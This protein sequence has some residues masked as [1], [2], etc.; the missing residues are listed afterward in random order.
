[1]PVLLLCRWLLLALLVLLLPRAW[2]LL[3]P[4]YSSLLRVYAKSYAERFMGSDSTLLAAVISTKTDSAAAF[5][6]GLLAL[7]GWCLKAS[8]LQ[9]EHTN[10]HHTDLT[11]TTHN[12][13]HVTHGGTMCRLAQ[14]CRQLPKDAIHS[15][16]SDSQSTFARNRLM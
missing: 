10:K 1:M 5:A 12:T 13:V 16:P 15:K 8:L 11:C 6:S 2:L 9:V 7:S 14:D 3:W 4:P